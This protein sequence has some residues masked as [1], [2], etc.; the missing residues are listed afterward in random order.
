MARPILVLNWPEKS[1]IPSA[2]YLMLCPFYF[3]FRQDK[4]FFSTKSVP[5]SN[6][7]HRATVKPRPSGDYIGIKISALPPTQLFY[8]QFYK[9]QHSFNRDITAILYFIPAMIPCSLFSVSCG[10]GHIYWRNPYWKTSFFVQ[11]LLS[12]CNTAK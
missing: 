4:N 3:E 9:Y 11:L 12:Q 5:S 10:F 8:S 6:F 2:R 7:A 1:I